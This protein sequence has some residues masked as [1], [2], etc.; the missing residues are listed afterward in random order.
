MNAEDYKKLLSELKNTM[1]E[2]QSKRVK[3]EVT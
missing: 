1:N 2:A 3:Y